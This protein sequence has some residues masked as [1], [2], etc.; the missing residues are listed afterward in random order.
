MSP[1]PP[2]S[3]L[4]GTPVVPGVAYAP[5]VDRHRRGLAD[6]RRGLR[7]GRLPRRRGGAR[8]V[9]RRGRA[10]PRRGSTARAAARQR[11][12]RRGA[13]RHRR[14]GPDKGLRAAVRKRLAAGDPLLVALARRG[15]AVR[16]RLHPDGRPDGRA[17]HRPARHR[18]PGD[19]A[20]GRRARAGRA[21]ARRAV[22]AGRRG[23]RAGRHRRAR[24]R[25][26]WSPWSPRRAAPP[27]TP[28]SSP[29]SSA[30]PAWSA[31]PALLD[32]PR[33]HP[34]SWSTAR[35]ARSTLEPGRRG[36]RARWSPR[37]RA[38]REA[39]DR[40]TGPGRTADGTPVK[41]LANVADGASAP[42]PAAGPGRGRRAVPHRAVLP[43][44]QGRAVASRSRPTS[45][46]ACSR[47]FGDRPLR[48]GPHP[49][50]RLGQADR[51][52]HPRGR[53]EPRPRRPRA[54]AVASTTPA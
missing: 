24:R 29:A 41:L 53:G 46:P 13:H 21:R 22:G 35:R 23:P 28:R 39:L 11:R 12:G 44:P 51:L 3:V 52:R 14:A 7:A 20:P 31:S 33:R 47:P 2:V 36:G 4:R 34:R 54:A 50:R 18:A 9:R 6:G 10:P 27:A 1:T 38:A 15:R 37:P 49:R 32:G 40:W 17:G 25:A 45:T 43:Q 19:R 42:P 16:R 26:P 8:G 30:S 5:A 48:R